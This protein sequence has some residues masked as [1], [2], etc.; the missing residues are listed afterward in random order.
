M[1]HHS[2]SALQILFIADNSLF[3]HLAYQCL[4]NSCAHATGIFWEH[5][6]V[7]LPDVRSWRGDWIL[8]FKSDFVLPPDVLK[9]ARVSAINFHPAP[10]KYRGIG[11]Y[12]W[13]LHHEDEVYGVTCHYMIE[14]IDAGPIIDVRRFPILPGETASS[15]KMRAGLYCLHLF[16]ELLP[17]ILRGEALPLSSETWGN[18]LY[19]YNALDALMETVANKDNRTR[20]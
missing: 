7:P 16:N 8:S 11:A 10:P 1:N 6:D 5:G 4:Q 9:N 18:T 3:S 17:L 12:S 2:K 20:Q 19:T 14:R 15:L 13:A